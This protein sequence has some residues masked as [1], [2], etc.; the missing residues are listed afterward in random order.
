MRQVCQDTVKKPKLDQHRGRCRGAYF[1][2][3][4]C[5]KTFDGAEYR[6]HTSCVSEAERYQRSVYKPPPGSK[7]KSV[8]AE[9]KTQPKGD[10]AKLNGEAKK[11]ET[12][13][14][15]NGHKRKHDAE[16]MEATQA[17]AANVTA[18][19]TCL[20]AVFKAAAKSAKASDSKAFKKALLKKLHVR[21]KDGEIVITL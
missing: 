6:S 16:D 21:Q 9:Q 12:L 11:E 13:Q 10:V 20:N 1:T 8:A 4:D 15:T 14:S 2:C 17:F 18:T 5:N 19:S 3:L 7:A